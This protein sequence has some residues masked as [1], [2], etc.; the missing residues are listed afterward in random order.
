MVVAG[1]AHGWGTMSREAAAGGAIGVIF[2]STAVKKR[3]D[4][5]TISS[6]SRRKRSRLGMAGVAS[7][8][9][10]GTITKRCSRQ[11][12]ATE[13]I[14]A[15]RA[16]I[17]PA[18]SSERALRSGSGRR[19]SGAVLVGSEPSTAL[20]IASNGASSRATS[21]QPTM[22]IDS[23]MGM[24]GIGSL[25]HVVSKSCERAVEPIANRVG[26]VAISESVSPSVFS[27]RAVTR[28]C[29][30][31]RSSET[32]SRAVA[33]VARTVSVQSRAGTE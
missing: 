5:V 33:T 1:E 9:C 2:G 26:I 19:G 21:S 32:P 10:C 24:G 31:S 16:A 13:R 11:E 7:A 20:V 18:S 29:G 12:A 25:P 6:G 22:S 15:S 3:R 8:L 17:R 4:A 28:S 14:Q 30:A 27:D 23:A